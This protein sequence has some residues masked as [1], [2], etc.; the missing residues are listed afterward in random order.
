MRTLAIVTG[1]LLCVAPAARA[2]RPMFVVNG[3]RV[4]NGGATNATGPCHIDDVDPGVIENIEVVK[5]VAAIKQ[6]GPDAINGVISVTTKKGAIW[7]PNWSAACGV[8]GHSAAD[9]LTKYLYAPE[10]VMAHEDTIR[11]SD[12]QRT[13]IQDAVKQVQSKAIDLQFRLGAANVK[14]TGLL[15]GST[16]DESAVLQQIDQVLALEREVKRAQITLLVQIKNQLT[17]KQQAKLDTW[18]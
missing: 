11:L 12:F 18:K 3:V 13:A 7:A 16:V 10:F 8:P 9:L 6:Y 17:A 15:A 2:Q 5:G 4:D 1:V 14:L